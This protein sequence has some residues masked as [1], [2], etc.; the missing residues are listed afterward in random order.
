MKFLLDNTLIAPN[1]IETE[2]DRYIGWPGQALA[3]KIG[4]LEILRLREEARDRLGSR[5]DLRAVPR[6]RAGQRRGQPAGAGR[7][8]RPAGSTMSFDRFFARAEMPAGLEDELRELS[9]TGTIVFVMRSAGWLN[10]SFIRWLVRRLGLP[11]LGAPSVWAT[12]SWLLIGCR[13]TLAALRASLAI[14]PRADLPAPAQ[15]LSR[16][17]DLAA[18]RRVARETAQTPRAPRNRFACCARS[19]AP[20]GG[21]CTWCRFTLVAPAPAL[22]AVADRHRARHARGAG[23]AGDQHRVPA[24]LPARVRAHGAARSRSPTS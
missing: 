23:R 2:V 3:Y 19:S 18:N 12:S 7:A 9:R 5:F 10:L 4:E 21:R 15:R 14:G 16:Q 17:G 13:W 1:N 6:R 20:A 11:A 8:D 24:Q 22:E